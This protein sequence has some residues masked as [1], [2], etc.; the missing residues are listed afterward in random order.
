[1]KHWKIAALCAAALALCGGAPAATVKGIR[2]YARPE[3]VYA[4]QD[5]EVCFEILLSEATDMN[6][7]RPSGLPAELSL[8]SPKIDGHPGSQANLPEGFMARVVM[9]ARC[10][11]PLEVAPGRS[12]MDV[13]LVTR[14]QS[15]FGTATR[16]NRGSSLVE[17]TP[18]KILPLPEDGRPENFGGAIGRFVLSSEVEPMDLAVGDIARWKVQLGGS[19]NLNG[20]AAPLPELDPTLFRVY[21]VTGEGTAPGAL[22]ASVANIVPLSTNATEVAGAEFPYFDPLA[23]EYRVATARPVRV[24]V[25]ERGEAAPETVKTIDLA[26]SGTAVATN[27]TQLVQLYI[28]PMSSMATLLVKPEDIGEVLEEAETPDGRWKRVVDSRTGR[29]GWMMPQ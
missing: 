3:R 14:V 7:Y 10:D 26:A 4:G 28:A 9:P 23:G 19:G 25:R 17:W 5:F 6:V 18:F 16:M 12:S 15:L 2:A 29:S 24:R 20:A 1:M 13:E 21:P 11:R 8:G 27:A 22:A